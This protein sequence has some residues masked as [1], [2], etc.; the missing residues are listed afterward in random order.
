[1]IHLRHGYDQDHPAPVRGPVAASGLEEPPSGR[2]RRD[3][4]RECARK[5]Y[6]L[7]APRDPIAN[8]QWLFLHP[9]VDASV[10]G[11]EDEQF[12]YEKREER[13]GH[14]RRAALQEVR[15]QTGLDGV[16]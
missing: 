8:H 1:M 2:C 4:A 15:A 7:L 3:A 11:P 12:D 14:L 16:Q 6:A 9:W 10:G 13:I 5:A